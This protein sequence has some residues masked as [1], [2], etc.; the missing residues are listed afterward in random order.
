MA[1]VVFRLLNIYLFIL[2]LSGRKWVVE[3]RGTGES[4]KAGGMKGGWSGR[5]GGRERLSELEVGLCAI[6]FI[7]I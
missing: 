1:A 3:M 5:E 2:P 6:D 4:K 7:P